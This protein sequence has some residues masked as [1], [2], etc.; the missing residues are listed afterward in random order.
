MRFFVVVVTGAAGA[1]AASAIVIVALNFGIDWPLALEFF[2]HRATHT[3]QIKHQTKNKTTN[4]RM[5]KTGAERKN[6]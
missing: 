1:G 2:Q 3:K 4:K 5:I 6:K